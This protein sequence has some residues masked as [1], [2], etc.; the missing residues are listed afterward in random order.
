[1]A[2][3][4]KFQSIDGFTNDFVEQ[5]F[6]LDDLL[7][8]LNDSIIEQSVFTL[9]DETKKIL[10]DPNNIFEL[11]FTPGMSLNSLATEYIG[12]SFAWEAIAI[13][14]DL[15]PSKDIEIGKVLKIPTQE[16]IRKAANK[17]IAPEANQIIDS[18]KGSILD[19]TGLNKAN[20]PF[21]NNLKDCVNKVI[22]FKVNF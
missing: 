2:A 10:N 3:P 5:D 18:V 16:Q 21:A 14:N 1:M 9:R 4:L 19:L 6:S 15:D 11:E 17:I 12:D 7:F 8:P 20:T 13:L 22:D